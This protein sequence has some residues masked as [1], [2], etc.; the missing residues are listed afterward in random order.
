MANAIQ[1]LTDRKLKSTSE[2]GR[3]SDGGGLYLRV[4]NADAKSWAFTYR[5]ADKWIEIGLGGYPDTSLAKARE[6]A[7]EMRECIVNGIDPKSLRNREAE[8]TFG[9]AAKLLIASMEVEWSNPKHR[10][11]WV[12]TLGEAYCGRILK[13][14]VSEITMEDV[15]G[16]LQ[17]HWVAKPE[18]A[19]RLRGRI[20]RVLAFAKAKGWR[21]GDNP[22]TW[23]G[24]LQA[25]LPKP[26]K[27]KGNKHHAAMAYFDVPA[28]MERLRAVEG[29]SARALE[30]QILTASRSGEALGA[31]WEEID[32][33]GALWNVPA[34]RMKAR[35]DHTVPLPLRAVELLEAMQ[36]LRTSEYVFAGQV[37]NKPLSNMALTM[38]L[39][40]MKVEVTPHGFR[41]SFRDWAGDATNFQREVAEAALSHVIGDKAE[42]AYRRGTALDKRRKLMEAWAAFTANVIVDN[43]VALRA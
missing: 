1:K 32:L 6:T 29:L 15:L 31:K 19:S 40:R 38:L 11:Q 16:V 4:R 17:P 5:R 34:S 42:Q 28:F 26:S 43:V 3:Y 37:A 20:E 12:M 39:R 25:L 18:T 22:A 13:T 23:R 14:L 7:T 21:T 8:P 10:A 30:F 36:E 35:R 9:E 41:S 33:E 27:L 2:A 24:N